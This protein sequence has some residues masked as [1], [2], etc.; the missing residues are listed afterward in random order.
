MNGITGQGAY[1]LAA[2]FENAAEQTLGRQTSQVFDAC[3]ALFLLPWR[4]EDRE[5]F[6]RG[7]VKKM[8]WEK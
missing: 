5:N 7:N 6:Q 2:M 1:E 3:S 8:S 4:D